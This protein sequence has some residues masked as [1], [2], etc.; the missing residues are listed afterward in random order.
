MDRTEETASWREWTKK[1]DPNTVTEYRAL[2]SL[3]RN[4]HCCIVI[5]NLKATIN[6]RVLYENHSFNTSIIIAGLQFISSGVSCIVLMLSASKKNR[7]WAA[8]G[9]ISLFQDKYSSKKYRTIRYC[10][11]IAIESSMCTID[12]Q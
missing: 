10:C 4:S 9:F 11:T 5:F 1:S 3:E 12:V 8:D 6:H 2:I 7:G